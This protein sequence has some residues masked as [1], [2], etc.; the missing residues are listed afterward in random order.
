MTDD[1]QK[2]DGKIKTE[3]L[4]EFERGQ[5]DREEAIAE[6]QN[7]CRMPN[8]P[9]QTF[10]YKLIELVKLAYPDFA[11]NIRK[12]IAKDYFVKGVHEDMQIAL[13]SLANFSSLDINGLATETIRLQLAGINSYS[14]HRNV[15]N[16]INVDTTINAVNDVLRSTSL[17]DSIADSVIKKLQ[18]NNITN[19]VEGSSQSN[20]EE[21]NNVHRGRGYRSNNRRGYRGY[22]GSTKSRKDMKCRSC[23]STDHFVKDC[24]TRFC[25]AC[26]NRGH[27]AWQKSCPN[28]Q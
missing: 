25:Q 1:D 4:K 24:P 21:I 20:N 19:C 9:A 8:E 13:K 17:V 16:D 10:A 5:Q 27:D 23:Q 3:L 28:H 14:K 22:Q 18:V 26:G 11:D 7:R 12:T 15:K 2:D 6:L